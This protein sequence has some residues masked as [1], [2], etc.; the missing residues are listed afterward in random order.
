MANTIPKNFGP[1]VQHQRLQRLHSLKSHF[2]ILQTSNHSNVKALCLG[3]GKQ[4]KKQIC[5]FPHPITA[6]SVKLHSDHRCRSRALSTKKK[7]QVGSSKWSISIW[8]SMSPL[9][10]LNSNAPKFKVFKYLRGVGRVAPLSG[11]ELKWWPTLWLV[12]VDKGAGLYH[13]D[14]GLLKSR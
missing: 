1:G 8:T 12:K 3:M 13:K 2:H 5:V 4:I 10:V 14:L 9:R 7:L 6:V 11:I